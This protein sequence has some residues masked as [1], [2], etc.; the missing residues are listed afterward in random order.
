MISNCSTGVS[1]ILVDVT[2][3]PLPPSCQSAGFF[4]VFVSQ[5]LLDELSEA[6]IRSFGLAKLRRLTG[7]ICYCSLA[8]IGHVAPH[9][10]SICL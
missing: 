10:I 9:N 6:I 4:I 2:C 1:R 5:I 7:I 3:S 8:T